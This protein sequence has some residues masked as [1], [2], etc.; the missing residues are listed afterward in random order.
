MRTLYTLAIA[1]I[2]GL[3]VALG[4]VYSGLINISARIPHSAPV[5]WLLSTASD[6]SIERHASNVDVPDLTD[7]DLIAAG[8]SDFSAMCAGCHGAPGLAR[9]SVGQGLNPQAPDLV[10][11]AEHRSP[12]EIF[13]VTR[14]GIRMTGM[15]AWGAS[16]EDPAL[17]PVVALVMQLPSLDADAFDRLRQQGTSLSHHG[18]AAVTDHDHGDGN[19][20][21]ATSQSDHHA[22]ED[23]ES[24]PAGHEGHDHDH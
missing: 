11:A 21:D 1:G 18:D 23:E 8:A 22:P 19:D 3:G 6:A 4:L 15:P 9:D 20:H 17:W 16:H 14:E 12:N 24:V 5:E 10:H 13:W 7:P 2:V